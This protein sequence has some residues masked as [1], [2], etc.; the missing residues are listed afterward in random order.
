[1]N[2]LKEAL[3]DTIRK[4]GPITFAR[5]MQA[6]LYEPGL[7]Y[8]ASGG[9]RIGIEGDFYTSSHLSAAFGSMLG[10]QMEE[11]WGFMGRPG[12]FTVLEAGA[13]AGH[14][15]KDMLDYLRDKEIFGSL[16]YMVIEPFPHARESQKKLLR[17]YEEKLSWRSSL[18]EI[19]PGSV[20]GCVLTNELLDALPVHLVVMED[21]L[22]EIF[23]TLH[24]KGR[25]METSGPPST[26]G[27]EEYFEGFDITLPEGYRTEVCLG[28]KEWL[29]DAASVLSGGFV[30]TVDYGYDAWDYYGEDRS[31]GT[32]LCYHKHQSSGDP[33]T[34]VGEKDI[35][36]HVNFS[37]LKRWGEEFG[38]KGLGFCPQSQYLVSLGLDRF[39]E[40]KYAGTEDYPFE[41][42]KIKGLI[43]PGT[44]GETHKVLLQ[45]KGSASTP[46]PTEE[47]RGFTLRNRIDTL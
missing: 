20:T 42:A 27:L 32:L 11:L 47:P 40:E 3:A 23:V 6:A 2:P 16:G 29:R 43:M 15:A 22:K 1:M 7:G 46:P 31:S 33:L 28:A 24:D 21:E 8:Y 17:D 14:A 13:G 9:S 25:F 4:D 36:V 34:D 38:L 26:P 45:Y 35:S 39:I 30:I 10:V 44:M 12:E 5:F 18:R 41:V 19:E 37:A